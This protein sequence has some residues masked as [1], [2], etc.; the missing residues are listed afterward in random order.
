MNH[1]L[2]LNPAKVNPNDSGISLGQAIGATSTLII[3]KA[4]YGLERINGRYA[5]VTM[6]IGG[7]QGVAAIFENQV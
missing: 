5:L 3:V 2:G 7:D 4:L 6:C 1:D